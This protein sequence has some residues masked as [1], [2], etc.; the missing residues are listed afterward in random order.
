MSDGSSGGFRVLR[1]FNDPELAP[2]SGS[3]G[4]IDARTTA[5]FTRDNQVRRVIAALA[6]DGLLP[7]KE[8][9]ESFEFFERVRSAVRA[10]VVAD[11]AAGHGLTGLL[12]ALFERE[13][14]RVVLVDTHPSPSHLRL[15][16]ALC[17]VAPWVRPKVRW[18]TGTIEDSPGHLEPGT[19]I[20]AV[21]ACGVRTDACL[22]VAQAV[23]GHVAV[24]PCCHTRACGGPE[25][26]HIALGHRLASD[27]HR[28]YRLEAAGYSVTWSQIPQAITPMNRIL[29]G[30]HPGVLD[31]AGQPCT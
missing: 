23:G 25:A 2:L 22:D 11:L 21:H 10:P 19:S 8:V 7:L 6:A 31:R 12:F 30:L 15:L 17:G 24:L 9:C 29:V 26:L 20:V 14:E 4:R 18:V 3:H 13:V 27:V 28:T 1:C 16:D 5:L